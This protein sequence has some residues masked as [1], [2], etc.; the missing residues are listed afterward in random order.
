MA[1]RVSSG[2]TYVPGQGYVETSLLSAPTLQP[3]PTATPVAPSLTPEAESVTTGIEPQQLAAILYGK[4]IPVFVGGKMRIG[5]R[6]IEGPFFGGTSDAPTVS[7][8]ASH[9]LCANPAGTRSIT[10]FSLRGRVAWTLTDGALLDGLTVEFKTGSETQTPFTSSVNRYG[11]SAIAYRGHILS[12]VTDLPLSTFAGIVPFPSVLVEDSTFG[13]PDD[14]ITREDALETILRYARL[15]DDEFEVDVTGSDIAW[16]IGQKVELVP[17]LQQLR[18]IFVNWN[19]TA[20]DKL[21]IIEPGAFSVDAEITRNNH[22]ARSMRFT[23]VEPLTKPR[24]KIYKFIDLARDYEPNAATARQELFPFPTTA[25][26]ESET[27][28]L[29]IVTEA[30]QA[31]VDVNYSLFQ[32]EVARK[33]IEYTGMVSL[34]GHEAGDGIHFDDHSHFRFRGRVTEAV[35][36]WA[37][38]TVDVKAETWLNCNIP[39]SEVAITDYFA[40]EEGGGSGTPGNYNFPDVTLSAEHA[41]RLVVVVAALARFPSGAR[42]ITSIDIGGSAA[43]IHVEKAQEDSSY[44]ALTMAI[45]SRVVASGA[46]TTVDI[47]FDGILGSGCAIGVYSFVPTSATPHATASNGSVGSDPTTTI[48]VPQSGLV[49]SGYSGSG[50]PLGAATWT[51]LDTVGFNA[52]VVLSANGWWGS[53]AKQTGMVSSTGRIISV[54]APAVGNEVLVAASWS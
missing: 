45:A 34:L 27:I 6:I 14:G 10:E 15:D 43:T 37:D 20:T 1:F 42:D 54:T 32:A 24:E 3:Q 44:G 47:N 26:I 51:G 12:C 7:Y 38:L 13:D 49:I 48:D 30:S 8:I 22:I 28:E 29:P 41:S 50:A 33:Q 21:R 23:R 16:I 17:F 5:G 31:V 25:S 35:K 46:T 40:A 2:L 52:Q 18:K 9:A 19:V 4:D 11:D 36:N 53:F 39:V